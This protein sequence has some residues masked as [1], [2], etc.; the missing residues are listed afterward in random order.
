MSLD[1][2]PARV[3][4]LWSSL[5]FFIISQGCWRFPSGDFLIKTFILLSCG[6]GIFSALWSC[7]NPTAGERSGMGLPRSFFIWR[8]GPAP[9]WQVGQL[10]AMTSPSHCQPGDGQTRGIS[11]GPSSSPQACCSLGQQCTMYLQAW[12]TQFGTGSCS[13]RKG[14]F[15]TGVAIIHSRPLSPQMVSH[16]SFASSDAAAGQSSCPSMGYH[17]FGTKV[18]H[19]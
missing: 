11:A 18:R 10:Q 14:R 15:V 12:P 8:H 2:K 7:V 1:S 5:S 9:A 4:R 19:K 3:E 16:V 6:S 17:H 13:Q